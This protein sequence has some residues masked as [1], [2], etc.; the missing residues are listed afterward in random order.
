[1]RPRHWATLTLDLSGWPGVVVG[2]RPAPGDLEATRRTLADIAASRPEGL[3]H[4]QVSGEPPGPAGAP[5][6]KCRYQQQV[7][8]LPVTRL[9]HIG[10]RHK[11]AVTFLRRGVSFRY[12]P[13]TRRQ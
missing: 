10:V 13:K 9:R 7:R 1:V 12:E 3:S 6:K 5:S 4:S 2:E 11:Q 8:D